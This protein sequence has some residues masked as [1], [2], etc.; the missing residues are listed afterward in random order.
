MD[1]QIDLGLCFSCDIRTLFMCG[2]IILLL[3]LTFKFVAEDNQI[4]FFFVFF[5]KIRLDHCM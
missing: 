2:S 3:F 1:A 4:F 5:E